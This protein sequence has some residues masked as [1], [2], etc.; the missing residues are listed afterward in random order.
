[1]CVAALTLSHVCCR[2]DRAALPAVMQVKNFG[3][4]GRTKWTHLANEDTTQLA[5]D[6]DPD[7]LELA[8]T[9]AGI[10]R[11]QA[12]KGGGMMQQFTKPHNTRT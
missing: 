3:R 6:M 12:Q 11:K 7:A 9:F 5:T 1:M 2:F 10:H 4:A 8:E